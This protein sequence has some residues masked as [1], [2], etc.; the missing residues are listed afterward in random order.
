M[1]KT[2]FTKTIEDIKSGDRYDPL[3]ASTKAQIKRIEIEGK[4][5]RKTVDALLAAGFTVGVN[6]GEETVLTHSQSVND[7]MGALY[8][9]D[10]DYLYAYDATTKKRVGTVFFVY[11]NDGPDVIC[12]YS[13]N[14]SDV[15]APVEEYAES[16]A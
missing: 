2:P 13:T 10:A 7:V 5:A 9:T 16:L 6:D 1:D 12:D 8:S 3:D 11:G 15:L 14:M 4:I